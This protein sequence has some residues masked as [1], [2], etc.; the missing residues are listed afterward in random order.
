MQSRVFLVCDWFTLKI[1]IFQSFWKHFLVGNEEVRVHLEFEGKNSTDWEPCHLFWE[2]AAF[3]L[4]LLQ[5][6]PTVFLIN[7]VQSKGWEA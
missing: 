6:S 2:L 7:G 1:G 3:V 5:L 4:P